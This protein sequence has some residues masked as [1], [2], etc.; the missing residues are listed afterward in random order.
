MAVPVSKS[1]EKP[2]DS[3]VLFSQD[4]IEIIDMMFHDAIT[5][6]ASDI[7][8]EPQEE[9]IAIR[10]R[11]DGQFAP[12]RQAGA[13]LKQQLVTRIKIL[14]GLKIDE[15]RLPQ[16]GKASYVFGKEKIDLRVSVLPVIYGE[17]VVI[18]ILRKDLAVITLDG[19]GILGSGLG[20]IEQALK[21]TFGIILS[22]GP[23]GS[24]KSTS[25]YALLQKFSPEAVNIST[26]EDPVEYT[27]KGVNQSQVNPDIG[28]DFSEGLRS[29]VRQDPDIIMVGEIRDKKTAQLAIESALTGHL[30]FSTLH[31]NDASTSVQRLTDM[32]VEAFLIS[33][34]VRLIIAQRLVRRI[35]TNCRI[36]Y[37]L[38]EDLLEKVQSEIGSLIEEDITAI[39]FYRPSACSEC[40]N[41]GYKGRVGIFEVLEFTPAIQA[42][43]LRRHV[44]SNQIKKLA[45]EE[46]MT[47]LIQDGLIKAALGMTSIEEVYRVAG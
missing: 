10:F 25:L 2:T 39:D 42:M 22:T 24:G 38:G 28:F 29:L 43:T 27:I 47:T 36:P 14:A 21:R 44:D 11:V 40:N 15:N 1:P 6:N 8:L 23:T 7:H 20:K 13:G 17:K 45:I 9:M 33:S 35:C 19:L 12:Y 32:G 4:A 41:L 37:R 18:R 34:A 3:K 5:M 31:T 46:G 30:V 16:D 26:L